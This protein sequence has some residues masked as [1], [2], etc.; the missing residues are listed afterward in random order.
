MGRE[1]LEQHIGQ[2]FDVEY[3]R[4]TTSLPLQPRAPSDCGI[5]RRAAQKYRRKPWVEEWNRLA[6]KRK[7]EPRKL[8]SLCPRP[9]ASV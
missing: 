7:N 8:G 4:K 2:D 1:I 5:S 9:L 6:L 3:G